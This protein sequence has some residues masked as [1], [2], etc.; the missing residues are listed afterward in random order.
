MLINYV[1]FLTKNYCCHCKTLCYM[2][3]NMLVTPHPNVYS[4]QG[5]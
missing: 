5:V 1:D 4:L 2:L 3:Y